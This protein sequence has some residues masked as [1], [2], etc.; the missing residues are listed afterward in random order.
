MKTLFD[1]FHKHL[2]GKDAITYKQLQ[3]VQILINVARRE[4]DKAKK[5]M[6]AAGNTL[7]FPARIKYGCLPA[8]K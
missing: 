3:R 4:S 7:L 1:V 6:A 5:T 8:P 2:L